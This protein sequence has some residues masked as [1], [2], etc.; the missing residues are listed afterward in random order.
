MLWMICYDVC[1]DRARLR[2]AKT[3]ARHG[4][5][6]QRSVYECHLGER[7]LKSLQRELLGLIDTGSDRVRLYPLCERDRHAVRVDGSLAPAVLDDV[8]F[9]L[10]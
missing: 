4:E 5:R 1:D 6:V 9:R 10:V 2:V 7:E 8:P 3:L